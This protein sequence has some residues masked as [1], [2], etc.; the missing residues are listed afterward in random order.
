MNYERPS[1]LT[2]DASSIV[3]AMGPA[4]AGYGVGDVTTPY[5]HV[6]PGSRFS[7]SQG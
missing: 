1:I 4:Q 6:D 2:L 5:E 7:G 3:E